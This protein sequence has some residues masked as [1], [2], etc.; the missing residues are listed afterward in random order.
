MPKMMITEVCTPSSLSMFE[1]FNVYLATNSLRYEGQ[2]IN[3]TDRV[4]TSAAESFVSLHGS[5]HGG[6]LA[7]DF[8][9]TGCVF[10]RLVRVVWY[11][12]QFSDGRPRGKFISYSCTSV[13]G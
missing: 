8:S 6:S 1:A 12:W 3:H 9:G 2:I 4:L 11:L 10:L 5:K 13:A 7:S